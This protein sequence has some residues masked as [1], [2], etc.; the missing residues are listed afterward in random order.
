MDAR[1]VTAVGHA[2]LQEGVRNLARCEIGV[3]E[4]ERHQD[5]DGLRD[6]PVPVMC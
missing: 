5:V 6:T 2:E 4:G 1:D 3:G